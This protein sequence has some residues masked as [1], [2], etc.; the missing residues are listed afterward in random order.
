MTVDLATFGACGASV[1]NHSPVL[2]S[3]IDAVA[4]SYGG[5]AGGGTIRIP[6]GLLRCDAPV[7]VGQRYDVTLEGYGEL[8]YTAPSG[9]LFSFASSQRVTMRDLRLSYDHPA[10]ADR[11]VVCGTLGSDPAYLGFDNV[12]FSGVGDAIGAAALLDLDRALM[13]DVSRC[14]FSRAQV[15]IHGQRTGYSN[16]VTI[17]RTTTFFQLDQVGI[18]NAGETWTITGCCFQQRLDGRA[19]AYTQDHTYYAR[20]LKFDTNWFGD[21]SQNGGTWIGPVVA[22]C[23][24]A[25]NNLFG[26]PGSGPSDVCLRLQAC[27]A[28][29]IQGNR[30]EGPRNVEFSG[31]NSGGVSVL[32]NDFQGGMPLTVTN[33]TPIYARGNLGL[34]NRG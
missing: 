21:V 10:Y 24:T 9:S 6:Q 26:S 11:L 3:A 5:A 17:G 19:G 8:R 1:A 18:R 28:V 34:S 14:R 33:T 27:Q 13:V 7:D 20:A 12:V 16:V 4:G 22:L 25:Q 2:Q 15:G 31:T 29:T 32:G 23:F 30:C